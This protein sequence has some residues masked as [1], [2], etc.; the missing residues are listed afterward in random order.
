MPTKTYEIT[1]DL[2]ML[3]KID[4]L[5]SWLYFSSH[6]GH[7]GTVAID[8]DGDGSEKVDVVGVNHGENRDYCKKIT[9]TVST[10]KRVVWIGLGD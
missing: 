9:G 7:S 4:R 1:A 2:K 10:T 6:W 5:M 8:L 3:K